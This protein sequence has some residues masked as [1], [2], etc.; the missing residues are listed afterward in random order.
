M[1]AAVRQGK[2]MRSVAR[3]FRVSLRTVQHWF[4][5][6][7]GQRLERVDWRTRPRGRRIPINRTPAAVERTVLELRRTLGTSV[8]GE[9]G[10]DAIHHQLRQA[11]G[12]TCVPTVRTIG[13]ILQ[14]HGAVERGQRQRRPAPPPGWYLPAAAARHVE[15]DLFD[16]IEDLK[17][18]G[19]PLIDVLTGVAL[20][21]GLPGA[22]PLRQASTTQL[23][24]CIL[25]RWQRWGLP[26]Y[27]QFDNDTRFQGGHNHPDVFGRV[28]RRCMELGV[29]PVFVP[30]REL[31]MQ[32][33]IENFNGLYQTKVWQRYHFPSLRALHA[34]S[35][36]YVAARCDRLAARFANAPAR[37]P[38]PANPAPATLL[39]PRGRVI[40]IRRTNDR[41]SLTV[42]GHTWR[43][44]PH[45]CHRLVR[46]E[47][48]LATARISC[49]GLRR[50]A[51]AEQPLIAELPYSYPR[52]D[53]AP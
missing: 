53:L 52:T 9:C 34:Q 1:V 31:G 29:T 15:V 6:A 7:R 43:I 46:A 8:L 27:A 4:R 10:A 20:H 13:R 19:G 49:Y 41:G 17:L 38:W 28:T 47:V 24:P 40:F 32:N 3:R 36:R 5:R 33:A 23:L 48:D 50:S 22:W 45:W 35:Q 25:A 2:S 39:L 11:P 26:G 21:G 30:P 14:R 42:L 37:L 51:P 44:D 18:A 12:L 16:V